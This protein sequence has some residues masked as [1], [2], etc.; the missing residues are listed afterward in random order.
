LPPAAAIFSAALPLNLWARTVS[1]FADLAARQHLHPHVALH[2]AR[3]AQQLGR[4]LDAGLEAVRQRIEVDDLVLLAERVVE[5]ALR[6]RAG[7]AA[8]G[9]LE[10][11][12]LLPARRDFAPL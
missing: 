3:L 2:Q 1:A 4:H 11:A 6:A 5:P 9:R 12:L 10:P 8:S 7:A